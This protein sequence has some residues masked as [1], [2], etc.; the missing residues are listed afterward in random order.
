MLYLFMLNNISLL[1]KYAFGIL[2]LFCLSLYSCDKDEN[3]NPDSTTFA[4]GTVEL[5]AL[6]KGA[7]DVFI[8]H[9]TLYKG[10]LVTTYSM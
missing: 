9:S 5:P 3:S 6:R 8:S 1:N 10:Q 2:C 7:D 4:T